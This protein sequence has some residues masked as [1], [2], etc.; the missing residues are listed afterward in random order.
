MPP[1]AKNK[2]NVFKVEAEIKLKAKKIA[3]SGFSVNYNLNRTPTAQIQLALGGGYNVKGTTKRAVPSEIEEGDEITVTY[4]HIGAKTYGGT[5]FEGI[6]SGVTMSKASSAG[7]TTVGAVVNAVHKLS[8]IGGLPTVARAYFVDTSFTTYAD[9]YQTNKTGQIPGIGSTADRALSGLLK[10]LSD[11]EVNPGEFIKDSLIALYES[12]AGPDSGKGNDAALPAVK[13]GRIRAA[14]PKAIAFLKTIEVLNMDVVAGK[15][16]KGT[17]NYK[18]KTRLRTLFLKYWMKSNGLSLLTQAGK[19]VYGVI[20]PTATSAY[21]APNFPLSK[22]AVKTITATEIFA[23]NTRS[24]LSPTPVVGVR[25]LYS[26]ID[27][28]SA[29]AKAG[30]GGLFAQYPPIEDKVEGIYEYIKAPDWAILSKDLLRSKPV[31]PTKI[32]TK[33]QPQHASNMVQEDKKNE[34]ATTED[35]KRWAERIAKTEY[36]TRSWA[37]NSFTMS[38]PMSFNL[39]PGMVIAID[40]SGDKIATSLF[41][42]TKLFG[43]VQSVSIRSSASSYSM[44]V[45]VA[46]VRNQVEN[47]KYGFDKHPLYTDYVMKEIKLY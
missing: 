43:Q 32:G 13:K 39:S 22:I 38:V 42:D 3:V 26:K 11:K 29:I 21:I 2:S 41:G 6:V 46:Y 15:A 19:H 25:L 14:N 8:L 9:D 28:D 40:V 36:N 17:T 45:G 47:E 27:N 7:G 34:K 18:L 30:A 24:S 20:I 33:I 35:L 31:T 12:E 1:I 16:I 44:Q 23:V 5:I 4:K 37:K 10:Q